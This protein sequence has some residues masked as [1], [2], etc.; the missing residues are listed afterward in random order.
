MAANSIKGNNVGSSGVAKDLTVA[1]V[2]EMLGLASGTYTPTLSDGLNVE[3]ST[4][5]ACYY[6]RVGNTVTVGGTIDVDPSSIS[7]TTIDLSLPITSNFSTFAG[8]GS[9]TVDNISVPVYIV[10]QLTG[11]AGRMKFKWTP[12]TDTNNTIQFSFTYNIE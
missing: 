8:G 9:G 2:K 3:S 12:T 7:A 6:M 10:P 1:E 4:A 5:R 11:G